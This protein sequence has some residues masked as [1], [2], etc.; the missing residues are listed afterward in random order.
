MIASVWLMYLGYSFF[1]WMEITVLLGCEFLFAGIPHSHSAL[2]PVCS[3]VPVP[4]P[5]CTEEGHRA[6]LL[7]TPSCPPLCPFPLTFL[8]QP[9]TGTFFSYVNDEEA[10]HIFI[11]ICL[12]QKSFFS[13]KSQILKL[14]SQMAQQNLAAYTWKRPKEE[15]KYLEKKKMVF[16]CSVL[17]HVLSYLLFTYKEFKSTGAPGMFLCLNPL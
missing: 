13:P 15:R 14:K 17:L 4:Q 7:S 11:I 12:C 5:Q 2:G 9:Q 16:Q 3:S 10:L 6:P 1:G 8:L